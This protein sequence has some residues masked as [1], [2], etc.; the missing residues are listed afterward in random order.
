M[1]S[2]AWLHIS[3]VFYRLRGLE[4]LQVYNVGMLT[5]KKFAFVRRVGNRKEVFV[6]QLRLNNDLCRLNDIFFSLS[7]IKITFAFFCFA[8]EP[9]YT[10]CI[11]IKSQ[12][13]EMSSFVILSFALCIMYCSWDRQ[14][15]K[16]LVLSFNSAVID[17]LFL[18]SL[19]SS[20]LPNY[21][22]LYCIFFSY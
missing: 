3:G 19:R 10:P 20:S 18:P 13:S 1:F 15:F 22:S 2:C 5:E 7:F 9:I 6:C 8:I 16:H 4:Y 11:L 17:M 14:C 21:F 12:L